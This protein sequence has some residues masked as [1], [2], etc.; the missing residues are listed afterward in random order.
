V[1]MVGG[2]YRELVTEK[3]RDDWER[4]ARRCAVV[5]RVRE[6]V[7]QRSRG[8]LSGLKAGS[9]PVS[10]GEMRYK[11]RRGG[12][13]GGT[14]QRSGCSVTLLEDV[15]TSTSPHSLTSESEGCDWKPSS[16]LSFLPQPRLSP[17]MR[18]M[19]SKLRS[20]LS[21]NS[22]DQ[23]THSRAPF[24]SSS[25]QTR[26]PDRHSAINSRRALGDQSGMGRAPG[27]PVGRLLASEGLSVRSP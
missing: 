8:P 18:G 23:S 22:L 13:G 16:F 10:E 3:E 7:K 15:P 1:N 17:T 25:S 14:Y 4:L 5:G 2:E 21:N 11:M 24:Q 6:V 27:T 20:K 9:A 12:E 19:P 26:T